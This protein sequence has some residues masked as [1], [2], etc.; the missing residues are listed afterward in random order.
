MHHV[1]SARHFQPGRL[2]PHDL[3]RF[4]DELIELHASPAIPVE[5]ERAA[6][7]VE[8]RSP[9]LAAI[10]PWKG[11]GHAATGG[12]AHESV[13][14]V[15]RDALAEEVERSRVRRVPGSIRVVRHSFVERDREWLTAPVGGELNFVAG[16]SLGFKD[17]YIVDPGLER[18]FD[19]D[20][21]TT[22][23]AT[24][25]VEAQDGRWGLAIIGRNLGDEEILNNAT[26]FFTN[27]AFLKA[28]RMVTLQGRYRV[29]GE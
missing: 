29:G 14:V 7:R 1:P 11:L 2:Q 26:P 19:Q 20:S 10:V 9:C 28:P 6:A 24:V 27:L 17:E 23:G 4:E 21:Y 18:A 12:D 5:E 13:P 16:L 25:G 22:V 3:A 15:V 8:E